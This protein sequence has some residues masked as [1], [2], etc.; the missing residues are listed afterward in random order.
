M[1]NP[2]LFLVPLLAMAVASHAAGD[3]RC[4]QMLPDHFGPNGIKNLNWQPKLSDCE[5]ITRVITDAAERD[6][7][8]QVRIALSK[9]KAKTGS[10]EP[11][12]FESL[13]PILVE[14]LESDDFDKYFTEYENIRFG[15][16]VSARR[17]CEA[18]R[19]C[20]APA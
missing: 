12:R 10:S 19:S 5:S 17:L 4:A 7:F 1:K 11:V 16:I 2:L 6:V 3:P 18:M 20:R 14:K 8:F 9:L 13:D 15:N